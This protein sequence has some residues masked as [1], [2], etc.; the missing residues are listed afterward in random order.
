MA[1]NTWA[2]VNGNWHDPTWNI[3]ANLRRDE[4]DRVALRSVVDKE[5]AKER[6]WLERRY[7]LPKSDIGTGVAIPDAAG[8]EGGEG[9]PRQDIGTG[10]VQ[11][12]D[13]GKGK[14]KA[15]EI[16]LADTENEPVEAGMG[17]EC[18]C[19]FTEYAFVCLID[20]VTRNSSC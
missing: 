5:F 4:E 16:S 6:R 3:D 14:G 9:G 7:G 13:N 11:G 20:F 1:N 12:V 2:P 19:C 17:V 18:Q 15:K 8:A 10:A